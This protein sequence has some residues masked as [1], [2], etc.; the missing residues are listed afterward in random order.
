VSS[1]W[2]IG[3]WVILADADVRQRVPDSLVSL[4]VSVLPLPPIGTLCQHLTSN[5]NNRTDAYGGSTEN[6]CRFALEVIDAIASVF[7]HD[8][9]GLK[10]CPADFM[11]DSMIS[12]QEMTEVYTYL[13][14]QV[15]ARGVGYV[16][17]SRRG[18][19]L[20]RG[21][22]R[23]VPLPVR[24]AE[25]SLEPGYEPLYEFGPLVKRSG[26]RTALMVNDE[27]TV[28]EAEQ[29]IEGGKI[30]LVSFGRLF[31]CNP[32][33]LCRPTGWLLCS[34]NILTQDLVHRVK[35]KIPFARNDRSR[36]VHYGRTGEP[37]RHF[38]DWPT[39]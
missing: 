35:K 1:G 29:L 11:G 34:D 25:K 22:E 8:R 36:S 23:Y 16:N 28:G 6:K 4:L 12:H 19:D 39:A 30:D 31:I 27:Y 38:T 24:P 26:S 20:G 37:R 21:G 5:L 2:D 32:V 10:I 9:V 15:V 14:E 7:G 3:R 17:V 18:V 13:I 33:S